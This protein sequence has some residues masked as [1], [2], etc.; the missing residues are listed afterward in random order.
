MVGKSKEEQNDTL[1]VW[2]GA[3]EGV[4]GILVYAP[5]MRPR[6]GGRKTQT[7]VGKL[8]SAGWQWK[9]TQ[10]ASATTIYFTFWLFICQT[11][12]DDRKKSVSGQ[13]LTKQCILPQ[14]N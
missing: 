9:D 3:P 12:S 6:N 8:L 2:I 13:H 5:G 7:T 14:N 1:I 10:P 4:F 11:T